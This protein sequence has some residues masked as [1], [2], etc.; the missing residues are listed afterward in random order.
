M[1]FRI[2]SNAFSEGGLIPQLN[3]CD[4]A[5]VSPSLEWSDAP[6]GTRSFALLVEDPDAPMGTW[7]HWILYD[8]PAGVHTLPQGAARVGIAGTSSFGRP[9]YG[10]PCPPAGRTHRYYFRLYALGVDTLGLPAG[11]SRA[12][13]DAALA[14]KV[15]GEAV[16]MGRFKR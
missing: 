14:E 8:I 4:G 9:G 3:S 5:D 11:A 15:V 12:A 6:K 10:G 2:F 1:A 7:T 16:C 13:F